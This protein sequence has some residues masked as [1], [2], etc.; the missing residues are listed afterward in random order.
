MKTMSGKRG[1]PRK[2]PLPEAVSTTELQMQTE[3]TEPEV[4]KAYTDDD[5]LAPYVDDEVES[6]DAAP[7]VEQRA[8]PQIPQANTNGSVNIGMGDLLE[9]LK[10]ASAAN[11]EALLGTVNKMIGAFQSQMGPR[12]VSVA[13][14]GEVKTP[15]NPHGKKRE[16]KKEFFQNGFPLYE[17]YLSDDEIAMLHQIE[18]GKFGSDEFPVLVYEK[19]VVN[20]KN[21]VHIVYPAGKDD[22][23]REKMFAPTFH[24]FLV[25]LVKE[26]KDQ[27]ETKRQEALAFLQGTG[28]APA[29]F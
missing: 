17:R 6:V 29:T 5:L 27:L 12:K 16:L 18:P 21:R 1:R 15:F 14:L 28:P 4:Q 24:L 19:K 23:L 8:V 25:R 22:R 26:A 3:Q 9:L 13:E 11:N 7:Q 20:G 2:N 10:V